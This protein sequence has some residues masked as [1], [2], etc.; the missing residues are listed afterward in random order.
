MR[1]VLML[2]LV[3]S[4]AIIGSAQTS[5]PA[6]VATAVS[7]AQSGSSFHLSRHV[8][9]MI[10]GGATCEITAD[11]ATFYQDTND[12]DLVGN[13]RMKNLPEG[14]IRGMVERQGLSPQR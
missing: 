11:E 14:M 4:F 1:I 6:F 2:A 12:A 10:G 5:A 8:Q 7:A 9:I 13:V 3:V